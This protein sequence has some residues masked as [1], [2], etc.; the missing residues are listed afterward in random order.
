MDSG[1]A[2]VPHG[3]VRRQGAEGG[4]LA[5]LSFAAKDLF[6]VAGVPTG[7]GNPDWLS[8]HEPPDRSAPCVE[9]LLAAGATLV[10]KT[11]TDEL[12]YGLLG[13][14][15]HYGTPLN[16]RAPDRVPGGSSS[17]SASAVAAGAADFALGTDTGGSIRVPASFCGLYG[18]RT[19]HGRVPMAGV[20][21]LSPSYDT[22]GWLARDA[23]TLERVGR[24]LLGADDSP[25]PLRRIRVAED[26]VD[27][28]S[29]A[30][31]ALVEREGAVRLFDRPLEDYAA[32]FRTLQGEE[33][34]KVHGDWIRR[35]RPTFGP[36]V[37]ARFEWTSTLTPSEVDPCRALREEVRA[38]LLEVL[39][40]GTVLAFPTTPGPALL[41]DLDDK[42][43]NLARF[44]LVAMTCVASLCG[45][46][47]VSVPRGLVEGAPAGVSL[48]SAPGT[49]RAL[50]ALVASASGQPPGAERRALG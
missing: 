12:A 14:N 32:A 39:A 31:A 8:T 17:G 20:V 15:F 10:G 36:D 29:P 6:D 43:R 5:G 26:L 18:I 13:I 25:G 9:A 35:V 50:L 34:W 11:L 7:A 40:D 28:A 2:F 4:P 1:G 30:A 46:P 33:I 42:A 48:L 41:L 47:Q 21:P 45:L 19:T 16:P 37:G 24:V 22:V 3:R 27:A 23:A 49:D 38:R 44:P